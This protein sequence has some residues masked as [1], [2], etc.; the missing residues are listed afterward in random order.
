MDE[1]VRHGSAG[2]VGD[3]LPA[4]LHRDVLEDH[5]VNR[6]GPQPG[7]RWTA[8]NPARP[9]GGPRRAPGRRRTSPRAGR[10]A[11]APPPRPGSPPAD[12]TGQPPGQRHPPGPRRTSTRPR[13]SDPRSGPGPPT[14]WTPPGCPAAFPRF[15]FSARSAARRCFRGGFRPGRSSELGGIEE[16]P[17]FRDPAAP[18]SPAA[19]AGQRPPPPAP[20]SA[21]LRRDQLR[22]LPDQR[23][24]RILG[25]LPGRHIGH[26][27]QSS[28]KPRSATTATPRPTPERNPRSPT[29]TPS[30]GA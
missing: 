7:A 20:R 10:A 29:A 30:P 9:P 4:P 1:P 28:P 13:D 22:L 24:T 26:S 14:S 12:T 3:Q 16:F 2:H 8:R 11:P 5:Q 27:P 15:F 19:P 18:P 21:R 25:R 17:L 6:Q 23:I